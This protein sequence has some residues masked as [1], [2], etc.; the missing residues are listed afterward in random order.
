MADGGFSACSALLDA[1][2]IRR[3]R[4]RPLEIDCF[5]LDE[6]AESRCKLEKDLFDP[7][8]GNSVDF[9][10]SFGGSET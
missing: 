8:F 9:S 1:K 5:S 10:P 2:E 3:R 4:L 7:E 6:L